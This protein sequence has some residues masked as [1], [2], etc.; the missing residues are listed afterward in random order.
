MWCFR[1]QTERLSCGLAVAD[2]DAR[3]EYLPKTRI[4]IPAQEQLDDGASSYAGGGSAQPG[5]H[6]RKTPAQALYEAKCALLLYQETWDLNPE[7]RLIWSREGRSRDDRWARVG[8][9]PCGLEAS[10]WI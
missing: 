10:C 7:Q 8:H 9:S 4:L 1:G 5:E 3:P 2:E 6:P